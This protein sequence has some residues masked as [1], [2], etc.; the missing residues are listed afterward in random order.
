[1][2]KI[3][4]TNSKHARH[5]RWWSW[6]SV[7]VN[8][9]SATRV[10]KFW[11]CLRVCVV[12]RLGSAPSCETPEPLLCSLITRVGCSTS[13]ADSALYHDGLAISRKVRDFPRLIFRSLCDNFLSGSSLP[14]P[15]IVDYILRHR[16]SP[17]FWNWF[18]FATWN[19]VQ[20]STSCCSVNMLHALCGHM[21]R[22]LA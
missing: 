1:M 9:F 7:F 5:R 14:T 10:F 13:C 11:M 18:V 6:V 20:S 21:F 12:Y 15:K 8:D 17:Q 4:I 22:S 2:P 3:K 19:L 16:E